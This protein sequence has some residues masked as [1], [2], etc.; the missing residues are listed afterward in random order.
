MLGNVDSYQVIAMLLHGYVCPII[1]P[2]TI[3]LIVK[4]WGSEWNVE[5]CS[6]SKLVQ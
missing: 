6:T 1:K 2:A 4:P 5:S 3:I